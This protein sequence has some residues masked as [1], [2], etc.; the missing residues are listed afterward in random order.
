MA[1]VKFLGWEFVY[2]NSG[3]GGVQIGSVAPPHHEKTYI[4]QPNV[5]VEV[6]ARD[7]DFYRNLAAR[8]P[9]LWE[10]VE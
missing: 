8:N 2:H 4:F 1:C 9:D 10:V 5:C 3:Q 6:D 7:V